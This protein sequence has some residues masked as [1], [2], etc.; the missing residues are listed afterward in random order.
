M[1]RDFK[2]WNH[3]APNL[4]PEKQELRLQQHGLRILSHYPDDLL[5]TAEP[6]V[7]LSTVKGKVFRSDSGEAI[8]H[9]SQGPN[10]LVFGFDFL[11]FIRSSIAVHHI[12]YAPTPLRRRATFA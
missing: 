10:R 9:A 12:L 7:Q 6:F 11:S 4:E 5:F 3:I 2:T 8:S 1:L